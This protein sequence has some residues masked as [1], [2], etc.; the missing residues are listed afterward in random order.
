MFTPAND[1]PGFVPP[2]ANQLQPTAHGWRWLGV[3]VPQSMPGL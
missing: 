1:A 3:S 2:P